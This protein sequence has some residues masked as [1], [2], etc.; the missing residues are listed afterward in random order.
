M[1]HFM[2]LPTLLDNPIPGP[3]LDKL[4]S[5]H[6]HLHHLHKLNTKHPLYVEDTSDAHVSILSARQLPFPSRDV[7]LLR[8]Q[9]L[10]KCLPVREPRPGPQFRAL[11]CR[12]QRRQLKH[13]CT[14][15]ARCECIHHAPDEC[16]SCSCGVH[17]S[18]LHRQKCS[19]GSS[20]THMY[21]LY[22]GWKT[23]VRRTE[24]TEARRGFEA[25][26]P[27]GDT[28]HQRGSGWGPGTRCR[29]KG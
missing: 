20:V 22:F 10:R 24:R 13:A 21:I 23:R 7:T 8:Q 19:A 29:S 5:C 9:I 18:F 28:Q 27:T 6:A 25:Q 15:E 12:N 11:A 1:Q 26:D 4:C 14:A 16:I 17:H 3:L 2:G